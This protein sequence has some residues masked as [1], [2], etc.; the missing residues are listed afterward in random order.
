MREIIGSIDI[1]TDSIKLV[2][3]EF[4]HNELNILCGVDG[5]TKGFKDNEIV[6]EAALIKSIKSVLEKA[7]VKLNFKIKK[8]IANIPTSI[9]NF[10][11]SEATNT[12]TSE[13]QRVTSNDIL[14]VLQS[15]A[16]NKIKV[17]E[18]LVGLV[19]IN[20]RVGDNET[21]DPFDK[22]GKNITAK[23]V[24]ITAPKKEVYDII[25]IL[26]K[27][28]VEVID[29]STSSLACYYNFK[30][31]D[32]DNRTGI[33]VNI[34]ESKTSLSVFS[35]GIYINNEVLNT[36]GRFVDKDIAYMYKLK[37]NDSK[38]LKE[39]L[40]LANARRANPKESVKI[41]NK[42]NEE[43]IINQYELTEI[44]ASRVS[45]IL[46]MIKKS[47]NHLTKKEISY[48]IITG[49]LTELKDFNIA[50]TSIFG[51]KAEIGIINTL[52]VRNN[53]YSV[54]LG[55]IRNFKEKLALRHR[56]YSTVGEAESELMVSSDSKISVPSDSILG[57]VFGYFFDN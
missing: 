42:E 30:N 48:I 38:Y 19:P 9:N 54:A 11:V 31:S 15:T 21:T 10:V 27:C 55:I 52:G 51:E 6:D 50:M 5:V 2:V 26:E 18:E 44:V 57:K 37:R 16:Y 24:L 22:K 13:E 12:I 29:I 56:E 46:K 25:G 39:A 35:K 7:A 8:L 23:T 40:A 4:Y 36:G 3:C 32:I 1:G 33:I 47:I 20:F 14:R 45:E 41:V 53:K 49:G 34:G 17:G 43:L 28:G